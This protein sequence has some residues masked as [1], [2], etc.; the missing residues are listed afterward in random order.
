MNPDT[1]P[2]NTLLRDLPDAEWDV[3]SPHLADMKFAPAAVLCEADAELTQVY[4]PTAGVLSSVT[5]TLDG[6]S[7]ECF[8]SGRDGIVGHAAAYGAKQSPW[9]IV[10]QVPGEGLAIPPVAFA[11]ALQEMPELSRR[12]VLYGHLMQQLAGQS[13]ACNRFHPAEARLARWLL[14]VFDRVDGDEMDL[15]QEFMA[16]MI[17]AWRPTVSVAFA[18]LQR[19]GLVERTGRGR[20][21]VLDRRNLL[22][23]SCEC[24]TRVAQHEN[25]LLGTQPH[26]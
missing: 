9:R 4:F 5:T 17:G 1:R 19:A 15:T 8:L 25:T 14:T 26:P 20:I 21:R 11:E 24:Y 22:Q 6:G 3:I 10:V 7:V 23:A 2:A 13:I 12:L 16:Q 18:G